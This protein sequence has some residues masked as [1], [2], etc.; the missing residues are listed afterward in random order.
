[1]VRQCSCVL[2][3]I[4]WGEAPSIGAVGLIMDLDIYGAAKLLIDQH[5][6]GASLRTVERA[7]SHGTSR[8]EG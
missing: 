7:N 4:G 1:M 5:D 6:E 8:G 2:S 3:A